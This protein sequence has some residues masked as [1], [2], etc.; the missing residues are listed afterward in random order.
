MTGEQLKELSAFVSAAASLL[1]SVIA[2]VALL[3]FR[4][5]AMRA[6]NRVTESGGTVEVFGVK[7]NVGKATEE[8]QV[9][10]EDLQKQVQAL[11]DKVGLG[12]GA[13]TAGKSPG[14]VP[15]PEPRVNPRILWV[16]DKPENNAVLVA[17]LVNRGFQ[18]EQ[19]LTTEDAEILFDAG[20]FDIVISD[21]GRGADRAAGL[22]LIKALR[23]RNTSVPIL[24]FSSNKAAAVYR[25]AALA[26]GAD[27]ITDS[28]TLLLEALMKLKASQ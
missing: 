1:W 6:L 24:I 25:E 9:M 26:A 5:P 27:L 21:M 8:Q 12:Q 22:G 20:E 18:I 23:R 10:I 4:G 28:A 13:A 17:S 2:I 14:G 7:V 3:M 11:R 15:A 19:S 16:D